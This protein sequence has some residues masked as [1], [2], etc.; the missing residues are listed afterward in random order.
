MSKYPGSKFPPMEPQIIRSKI[1]SQEV[2]YPA[3]P[4]NKPQIMMDKGNYV[5][6]ST[7]F[8]KETVSK[9]Y[10]VVQ[11]GNLDEIDSYLRSNLSIVLLKNDEGKGPAHIILEDG[12]LDPS[13]K[14]LILKRMK[15][16]GIPMVLGDQ[17][18]VTPLHLAFSDA[19]GDPNIV[20]FLI[21]NDAKFDSKDNFGRTPLHYA[22]IGKQIE[23]PST[24]IKIESLVPK[25]KTISVDKKLIEK[26]FSDAT[27]FVVDFYGG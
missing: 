5:N 20:N 22:I 1:I 2:T 27:K 3:Y 23:C 26:K 16:Y 7:A 24:P 25:D 18:G 19:G 14:L 6:P 11:S 17:N 21:E 15:H 4:K 9:F 13:L 12:K 10:S 8:P